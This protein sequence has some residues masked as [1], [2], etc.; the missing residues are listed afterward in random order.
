MAELDFSGILPEDKDKKDSLD[1][2]GIVEDEK[3]KEEDKGFFKSIGDA[4]LSGGAGLVSG[5]I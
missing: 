4:S 1:F 2:S 5:V 3:E